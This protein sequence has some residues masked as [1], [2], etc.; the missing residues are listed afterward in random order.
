MAEALRSFLH[1]FVFPLLEGG[2]LRVGAPL[3]VR[4]IKKIQR[5]AG[6][7]S[8]VRLCELRQRRAQLLVPDGLEAPP[9]IEELQLWMGL[10]NVLALD[11]PEL[12]RVWASERTWAAIDQ[13]T[14]ALLNL[15]AVESRKDALARHVTVGAFVELLRDDFRLP[16]DEGE[17]VYLGQIPSRVRRT[18]LSVPDGTV[19][20]ETVRWVQTKA[21]PVARR[22]FLLALWSS[23]LTCFLRPDLAPRRWSP[24]EFARFLDHAPLLRAVAY[25]WDRHPDWL[26][27]GAAMLSRLPGLGQEAPVDPEQETAPVAAL[28]GTVAAPDPRSFERIVCLLIHLHLLKVLD[29][30]VRIGMGRSARDAMMQRFLSLPLTLDLLQPRWGSPMGDHEHPRLHRRWREY[31]AHL[32]GLVPR[33]VVDSTRQVLIEQSNLEGS[34]A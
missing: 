6:E 10:Y 26:A 24:L 29:F 1:R 28:A 27:L 22:A 4:E 15:P 20:V 9:D 12:S 30:D 5:D 21:H 17:Q 2:T 32:E 7:L 19:A 8:D 16:S 14:R 31:V 13:E 33:D 23:P 11:H 18:M 34:A 25:Q 3:S